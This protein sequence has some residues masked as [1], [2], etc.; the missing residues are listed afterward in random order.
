[1]AVATVCNR[2]QAVRRVPSFLHAID[3]S[4]FGKDAFPEIVAT[5]Q[6]I[7]D[8]VSAW[9]S[10]H[11]EFKTHAQELYEWWDKFMTAWL[12]D[13]GLL[14][15]KLYIRFKV[16]YPHYVPMYRQV[17][18]GQYGNRLAS[19]GFS[20][21]TTPIKGA[22]KS[23]LPILDPVESMHTNIL[24][25]VTAVNRR[26]VML[27]VADAYDAHPAK[28]KD[29]IVAE[30]DPKTIPHDSDL[31]DLKKQDGRSTRG[32]ST[33]R[34]HSRSARIDYE[35]FID[36]I[37]PQDTL[38]T[39]RKQRMADGQEIDVLTV[40]DRTGKQRFFHSDNPMFVDAVVNLNP[41][42]PTGVLRFFTNA[43]NGFKALI[44]FQNPFFALSNLIRDTQEGII[45]GS[46]KIPGQYAYDLGASVIDI[47]RGQANDAWRAYQQMGGGDDAGYVS[48]P[49]LSKTVNKK[50]IPFKAL[51]KRQKNRR[52]WRMPVE[53]VE[54]FNNYLETLSRYSEFARS[55]RQGE[56]DLKAILNSLEITLNFRRKGK[57]A[58]VLDPFIPS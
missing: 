33:R 23:D 9:E 26:Q 56:S 46:Q 50:S 3:R 39:F 6:E 48:G 40:I 53:A 10:E 42:D 45:W 47:V 16:M 19:G 21:V 27:A 37:L 20:G 18:Y 5:P 49:G 2:S 28:L 57:W 38:T 30:I 51:T 22:K 1:M 4:T 55:K 54:A 8:Q 12:V 14:E 29:F 52:K 7:K 25:Y 17:A 36:N 34:R 13:T 15:K 11:P 24:K 58:R 43:M 44:T 31:T 35:D 41:Q 32:D